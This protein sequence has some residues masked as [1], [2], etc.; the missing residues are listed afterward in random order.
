MKCYE[1][2]TNLSSCSSALLG[3]EDLKELGMTK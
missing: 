2:I 1:L 3:D